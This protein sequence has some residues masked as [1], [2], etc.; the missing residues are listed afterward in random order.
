MLAEDK[1]WSYT[2]PEAVSN[3]NLIKIK[4]YN[5]RKNICF[6][7]KKKHKI[8]TPWLKMIKDPDFILATIQSTVQSWMAP[9]MILMV[10]KYLQEIHGYS[11]KEASTMVTIPSNIAQIIVGWVSA[12]VGDYA[13]SKN[14]PNWI[15]RR[16]AAI[17]CALAATPYLILPF[18]PC[19]FLST[20]ATIVVIQVL[21][22]CRVIGN[23]AGYTTFRLHSQLMGY[24]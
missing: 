16:V 1:K 10:K 13:V 11:I 19:E 12:Y 20:R 18:L 14:V 24:C 8:K 15:V 23:L 5:Y 17:L 2:P 6:I 4:M 7:K 21:G 22:S 3:Q 9:V